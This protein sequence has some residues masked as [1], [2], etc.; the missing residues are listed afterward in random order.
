M[1]MGRGKHKGRFPPKV[2]EVARKISITNA[3]KNAFSKCVLLVLNNG[4][5][6]AHVDDEEERERR[7]Q[8]EEEEGEIAPDDILKS[9]NV[10][11]IENMEK[12]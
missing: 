8:Q 7:R 5:V 9:L 11:T 10:C 6:K 2:Y 4:K 12:M 1:G 3:R